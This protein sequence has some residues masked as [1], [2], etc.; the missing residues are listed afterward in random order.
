MNQA[1]LIGI[2]DSTRQ[3][4]TRKNQISFFLVAFVL[5]LLPLERM[6]FPLSLKIADFALALLIGYGVYRFFSE[7]QR[8]HAPLAFPAWLILAVSL[9]AVLAAPLNTD[10]IIAIVQEIYLFVWFILLINTLTTLKPSDFDTLIKIW[11]I[12]AILEAITSLMGMMKIGPAIFYTSPI[13]GNILDT[14]EF[15]RGFGTFANPNATGAY[16][17]ISFFMLQATRWPK[18]IR[19]VLGMFMYAG[20]YSSGSMGAIL[21]TTIGFGS[22]IFL[23]MAVKNQRVIFL[24][25]GAL[26]IG[27]AALIIVFTFFNPMPSLSQITVASKGNQVLAL[28]LGRLTHSVSGRTDL[29]GDAEQVFERYPFGMGPNTADVHNDYIA[30]LFDRGPLGLIGWLLLVIT[31]LITPLWKIGQYKD[32]FR[33][34]QILALWAGF[35]AISIL[36]LTH[37]ISHFRQVWALM[38]FIYAAYY[39]FLSNNGPIPVSTNPRV[40]NLTT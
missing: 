26:A 29:L 22:L 21:G 38:A 2:S 37:E 39:L 23:N 3:T 8:I 7:K 28:T 15:N 27:M 5:V 14:G 9:L 18:W 12:V 32:K 36:A 34:W 19:V 30:F 20:I 13:K 24:L 16:L 10:S 31:T 17:A 35:L 25:T 4:T 11:S 33:C 40:E 6:S 1:S